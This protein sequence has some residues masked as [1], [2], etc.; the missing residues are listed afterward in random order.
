L[1][2]K[3]QYLAQA[4]YADRQAEQARDQ[5]VKDSWK[6]IAVDYRVLAELVANSRT[7]G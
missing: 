7:P 5:E 4:E 6:R 1:S 3:D 2:K